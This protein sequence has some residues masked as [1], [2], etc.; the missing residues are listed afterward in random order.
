MENRPVLRRRLSEN[1]STY[2]DREY[3]HFDC[4]ACE[5][6]WCEGM[7]FNEKVDHIRYLKM[8]FYSDSTSI[9]LGQY[10]QHYDHESAYPDHQDEF[11]MKMPKHMPNSIAGLT[12]LVDLWLV[13]YYSDFG[14][15]KDTERADRVS[16]SLSALNCL[17]RLKKL[18]LTNM[19]VSGACQELVL[20]KLQ[21][22]HMNRCC[23]EHGTTY[24]VIAALNEYSENI[25]TICIDRMY[26]EVQRY[27][28]HEERTNDVYDRQLPIDNMK[29]LRSLSVNRSRLNARLPDSIHELTHLRIVNI[30]DSVLTGIPDA[31]T[32]LHNLE[33]FYIHESTEYL[34]MVSDAVL[35][36][37]Y[38]RSIDVV[39]EVD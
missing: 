27:Y 21:S 29:K 14:R 16:V 32:K 19:S 13:T 24:D 38:S 3:G 18:V 5:C 30:M 11:E 10:N 15:Y 12:H 17:G 28:D 4:V 22:L 8:E 20:P 7:H 6:L 9:I 33:L 39:I 25:D 2:E 35:Q 23:L 1:C 36:M 31:V 34:S 26:G 37:K